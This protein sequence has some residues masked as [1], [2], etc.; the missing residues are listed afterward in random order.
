MSDKVKIGRKGSGESWALWWHFD[1]GVLG[2]AMSLAAQIEGYIKR[3]LELSEDGS[4]ELKRADLAEMFMC[5][6]SQI[7][8]VLNTRFSSEAGYFIETRRG[9]AG[10][11][12]IV[13]TGLSGGGD[14]AAM[15]SEPKSKA[16]GRQAADNLL[17]RLLDEEILTPREFAI[18]RAMLVGNG[19]NSVGEQED[20]VRGQLVRILLLNLLREDL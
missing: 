16:L 17:V 5:V 2:M 3:L 6:P 20:A 10:Y 9:G 12:R 4:V 14:L 15:L 7:N 1:V 19:L 11:V 13:R 8:Y 18:F